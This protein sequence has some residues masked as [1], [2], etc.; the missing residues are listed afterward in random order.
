MNTT[1]PL[2]YTKHISKTRRLAP[3]FV[4]IAFL[5]GCAIAPP[6]VENADWSR[7]KDQLEQLSSW[8]MRGRVNVRY[9]NEAH[10]PRIQW[11]QNEAQYNIRLWG[12]F[13]VG[14]TTIEGR[15]GFVTLEQDG[16]ELSA[17]S[18]EE[19]ILQQL[20]YELPVSSL[21]HWIKGIP[22]PES[23]AELQFSEFNQLTQLVQDGWTVIF[24]DLRQYGEFS[25]PRRVELTRPKNDIRLRFIG[26]SWTTPTEPSTN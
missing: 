4:A 8:Q 20:G 22:A 3:L 7:H 16:E 6:A 23:T 14:S 25:L 19:L 1:F 12:T 26:I 24:D 9:D 17:A 13:N 15:P 10:T 11:Q 18:P 21:E 2:F 5:N